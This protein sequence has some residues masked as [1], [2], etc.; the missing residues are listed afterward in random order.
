MLLSAA[1]TEDLAENAAIARTDSCA[2]PGNPILDNLWRER[3]NL[4]D[5]LIELR[6]RA[7]FG[8]ACRLESLRGVAIGMA[9][10]L[11]KRFGHR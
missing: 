2:A 1:L 5:R 7:S 6:P 8:F 4:C 9:K 11:R 10:L 3:L